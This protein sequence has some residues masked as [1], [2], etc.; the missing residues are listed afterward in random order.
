MPKNISIIPYSDVTSGM[1]DD[2]TRGSNN[3]DLYPRSIRGFSDNLAIEYGEGNRSTY[4]DYNILNKNL[5][6]KDVVKNGQY[7]SSY[8]E[9]IKIIG[10]NSDHLK[11]KGGDHEIVD[12]EIENGGSGYSDGTLTAEDSGTKFLANYTV[13]S[14]GAIEHIEIVHHGAGYEDEPTITISDSSGSN[15]S[16]KAKLGVLSGSHV[17]AHGNTAMLNL[18]IRR[19]SIGNALIKSDAEIDATKLGNG[20]VTNTELSYINSVTSNVQTQLN[21]MAGKIIGYTSIGENSFHMSYTLTTSF[22]VPNSNMKV[23]F[24]A[25]T[26]GNVEIMAQIYYN[27]SSSNRYFYLGLS[28]S[29]TYNTIGANYE[30]VVR[31]ADE[32]DDGIL[33]NFWT[34]TGLTAGTSYTYYL[35]AKINATTGYLNWGGN[36]SGRYCDFIMKAVA[37]P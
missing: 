9:S 36:T 34:I 29:S 6:L 4:D 15:A 1:E 35:G 30:Q 12:V 27:S 11:L 24:T 8:L 17:E 32:T 3:K 13:D 2:S 21:D 31:Y 20:D 10:L 7:D 19:D 26:S 25:P 18:H 37:L 33:Q 14:S 22:A 23:T 16:L 28:D 5:S